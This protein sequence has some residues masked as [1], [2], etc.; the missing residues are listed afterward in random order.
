MKINL[1]E[2]N[3]S[4]MAGY[5][6]KWMFD[7]NKTVNG[8][9]TVSCRQ[10]VNED[11]PY[12]MPAA[13]GL[14]D[15][16]EIYDAL[17]IMMSEAGYSLDDQSLDDI[18]NKIMKI[19]EGIG[20]DFLSA[21]ERSIERSNLLKIEMQKKRTLI[22]APYKSIISKYVEQF[23]DERLRNYGGS[24]RSWTQYFIEE[25]I[26]ANGKIPNGV[27]K[28]QVKGYSGPEHDFTPLSKFYEK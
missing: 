21:P 20:K 18:S 2:F 9:F 19:D 7:L 3:D 15:A 8:K 10:I 6:W 17:E 27:H 5:S 13:K 23:D 26:V 14:K 12:K 28:I 1:I 4:N 11:N 22:L 24:R 16:V 25:Y